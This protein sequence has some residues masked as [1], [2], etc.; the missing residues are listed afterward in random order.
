MRSNG[1]A[2][3]EVKDGEAWAIIKDRDKVEPA[4]I[5]NNSTRFSL[6]KNT[7]LMSTHM[8]KKLSYLAETEYA[9]NILKGKFKVDPEMDE[10]TNKLLIFIGKR[11]HITTFSSE[12]LRDGFIKF[13][14]GAREKTSSSL[15]S[16]HFGHYKVASCS[17]TLS[18]VHASFQHVSSKSGLRLKR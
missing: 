13:W 1:I 5:N 9:T 18:E 4:I 3:V 17:N 12:V 8:S 7:P 16:H 10:Y 2:A 15:S 6:T 11:R 14:M